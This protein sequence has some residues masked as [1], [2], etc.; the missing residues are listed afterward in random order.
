MLAHLMIQAVRA[1]DVVVD[2]LNIDAAVLD[3]REVLDQLAKLR[4]AN[5]ICAIDDHGPLW[6]VIPREPH[7][8]RCQLV[9]V[10]SIGRFTVGVRP[11]LGVDAAHE[12]VQLR[13]RQEVVVC[14]VG[15]GGGEGI[16]QRLDQRRPRGARVAGEDD[17]RRRAG[18]EL[19]R[20]LELAVSLVQGLV[21]GRVGQLRGVLLPG[22]L[23][24]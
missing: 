24:A 3:T 11:A 22:S 12:V 13:R 6:S 17:A 14:E 7:K 21:G 18:L 16:A 2:D 9:V 20:L 1:G 19:Q 23:L 4:T 15:L 8:G 5:A 10:A